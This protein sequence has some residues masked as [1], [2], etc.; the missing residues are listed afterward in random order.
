MGD[1]VE[2]GREFGRGLVPARRAKDLN[3]DAL[4]QVFGFPRIADGTVNDTDYSALVALD[5]FPE[6]RFIAGFDA[7]H[8][9]DINLV[10]SHCR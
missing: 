5:Q 8:E 9:G 6:R 3:E 4:G 7:Q 2:P 1:G 10:G